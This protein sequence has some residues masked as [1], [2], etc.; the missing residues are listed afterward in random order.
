MPHWYGCHQCQRY[1]NPT[2]WGDCPY[3]H[4]KHPAAV[5]GVVSNGSNSAVF[6][7]TS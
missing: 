3:P 5:S 1:V 2:V 6:E 7:A 4:E